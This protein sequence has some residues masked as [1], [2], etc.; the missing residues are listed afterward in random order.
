[1]SKG[2]GEAKTVSNVT[3]WATQIPY[4]EEGFKRAESLYQAPGP[5][6][7]PGQTYV[8]FSP[9]TDLALKAQEARAKA[10]SPLMGQANTEMLKQLKGDYLD[11]TSNPFITNLYNKLAGDVTSGVQSQFTSAGRLGSGANQEVLAK[12]PSTIKIE[13]SKDTKLYFDLT[14]VS[15][16]DAQTEERI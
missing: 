1:M 14:Q 5:N 6:Y 7:F 12:F 8:D 11:P 16:F 2:A 3:P 4:L 13:L 15:L 9:Q 10:G